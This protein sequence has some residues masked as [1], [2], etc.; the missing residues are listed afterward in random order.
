MAA[1]IQALCRVCIQSL[2]FIYIETFCFL[3]E[4]NRRFPQSPPAT[5]TH[6]FGFEDIGK[7]KSHVLS[8]YTYVTRKGKL[9][10]KDRSDSSGLISLL[11]QSKCHYV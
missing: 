3:M 4:N 6:S 9:Q 10:N 5:H 11:P 2:Q 7:A 1:A 8:V